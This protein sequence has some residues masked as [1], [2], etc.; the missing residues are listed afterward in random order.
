[1]RRLVVLVLLL[2]VAALP[3]LGQTV[4]VHT[5]PPAAQV[6]D[7][8][9]W[10]GRTSDGRIKTLV[11]SDASAG[12]TLRLLDLG[13]DGSERRVVRVVSGVL[14]TSP[15]HVRVV[16]DTLHFTKRSEACTL[17]LRSGIVSCRQGSYPIQDFEWARS[18]VGWATVQ[19]DR[20]YSLA[21][22]RAEANERLAYEMVQAN[23]PARF[24]AFAS[25]GVVYTADQLYT[26]PHADALY[27]RDASAA[28]TDTL[29]LTGQ[30]VQV[31]DLIQHGPDVAVVYEADTLHLGQ[32]RRA[33]RIAYLTDR[34][35]LRPYHEVARF[36]AGE[37]LDVRFQTEG[38]DTVAAFYHVP[39][40]TYDGSRAS[41][42]IYAW[43]GH[44]TQGPARPTTDLREA[45]ANVLA[46]TKPCAA[47]GG[48]VRLPD[49]RFV[50]A[51][52]RPAPNGDV[53]ATVVRFLK[54]GFED[55][56]LADAVVPDAGRT[57]WPVLLSQDG[58]TVVTGAGPHYNPT[59]TAFAPLGATGIPEPWRYD[60]DLSTQHIPALAVRSGD[61]GLVVASVHQ[62][63]F[64]QR[65]WRFQRY[66]PDFTRDTSWGGLGGPLTL[67]GGVDVL[68]VVPGDS[69]Q[70]L[71]AAA[72]RDY[73][74]LPPFA[75]GRAVWD[76]SAS[77]SARVQKL[78][79]QQPYVILDDRN[80]NT[81]LAGFP[82]R[83]Y[84]LNGT[85]TPDRYRA[86]EKTV[87]DGGDGRALFPGP[88]RTVYAYTP[89]DA[90]A[91]LQRLLPDSTR[92][93]AFEAAA[94]PVLGQ[95][96][97][98]KLLVHPE[99]HLTLV[100]VSGVLVQL[101]ADGT[102]RA[103]FAP[104]ALPN[105]F[106]V[107]ALAVR[108]NGQLVL[109]GTVPRSGSEAGD[110]EVL[111]PTIVVVDPVHATSTESPAWNPETAFSAHPQP[112]RGAATVRFAART[113]GPARLELF[114]LL[115]RRI[116]T[117][118]DAPMRTGEALALPLDASGLAPGAYV[119]RLVDD[120]GTRSLLVRKT[121]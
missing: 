1:M 96:P 102:R 110:A 22:V 114:D 79:I 15:L 81:V 9:V 117:L 11:A 61:G 27:L 53:D 41:C 65:R 120:A 92:D 25:G 76:V 113:D 33:L 108:A 107:H 119:L 83:R 2:L 77:D 68:G 42:S 112:M 86:P 93:A 84:R 32:T 13:D 80:E 30:Q 100:L 66:R 109:S 18:G 105:R 3:A 10:T 73:P 75:V 46:R 47:N 72:P 60:Y 78:S 28:P 82:I 24:A 104:T 58:E 36:A 67:A 29:R 59:A 26:S 88:Q 16:N 71:V 70:A 89:Y 91:P 54:T 55:F 14:N 35:E 51:T 57:G 31:R 116:A 48:G 52:S 17:A 63:G 74:G 69:L 85:S 94:A 95:V 87:A 118:H 98:R 23:A 90:H 115:G 56:R 62:T 44:R 103:D 106:I 21:Q 50:L 34:G 101:N 121:P 97:V 4:R 45:E 99:G 64:A 111:A 49:G 12:T 19:I 40:R 38:P 39:G 6:M 5:L 43:Y 20:F 7:T 8:P 37:T